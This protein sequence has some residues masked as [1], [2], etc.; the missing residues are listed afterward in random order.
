MKRIMTLVLAMLM[1]FGLLCAC[2]E[3]TD[4][5]NKGTPGTDSAKELMSK[6]HYTYTRERDGETKETEYVIDIQWTENGATVEGY[7]DSEEGRY[8]TTMELTL[9]DQKRPVSMIQTETSPE[10]KTSQYSIVLAYE[11][12]RQIKRTVTYEEGNTSVTTYNFDENGRLILQETEGGEIRTYEYDAQGNQTLYRYQHPN[13]EKAA[14]YRTDYT[15]DD[16]GKAVFATYT[17]YSDD[18]QTQIHYYYYPNG[19]VMMEMKI[20]NR[21]EVNF[22]FRPNNPK[23]TMGWGYGMSAGVGMNMEYTVETD[24][25]GYYTKITRTNTQSG[26]S[27]TATMEYDANGNLVKYTGFYGDTKQWEYDS[28]NR[29]VKYTYNEDVTEYA[30]DDQGRLVSEKRMEADEDN[31]TQT[32]AYNEAGMTVKSMRSRVYAFDNGEETIEEIMEI[33]YTENANCPINNEWADFFLASLFD[34]T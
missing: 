19:N 6:I 12:E 34:V 33:E 24:A 2:G 1:C 13:L 15:Y 4:E 26:E 17:N 32:W 9:D 3:P 20:S 23:D 11:K 5:E 22:G 8:E 27:Q 31:A 30:Y 14:E 7:Q 25:N 16:A 29:L 18:E 21:G 28:Q 10:G